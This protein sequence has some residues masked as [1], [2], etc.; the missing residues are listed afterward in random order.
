MYIFFHPH[1]PDYGFYDPRLFNRANEIVTE[2]DILEVNKLIDF[3]RKA[4]KL[5][6]SLVTNIA[7]AEER[8]VTP[9]IF[10]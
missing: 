10:R 4:S 6:M 5:G 9:K 7:L 8:L 1:F 3:R 2:N